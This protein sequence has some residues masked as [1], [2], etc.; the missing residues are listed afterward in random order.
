MYRMS[1]HASC[2]VKVFQ[3]A[4][5][6]RLAIDLEHFERCLYSMADT[7]SVKVQGEHYH[8]IRVRLRQVDKPDAGTVYD[9][10]TGEPFD[11]VAY[12]NRV[13]HGSPFEPFFPAAQ[14]LTMRG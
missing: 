6:F 5:I 13:R 2:S 12:V 7:R 1:P 10:R 14:W 11:C 4:E 8:F 3:S 9:L